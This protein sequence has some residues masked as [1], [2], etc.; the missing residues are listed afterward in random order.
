MKTILLI[1]LM[2]FILM[3]NVITHQETFD[4]VKVIF[5]AKSTQT[6]CKTRVDLSEGLVDNPGAPVPARDHSGTRS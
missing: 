3:A 6:T 5:P 1:L 4:D 2:P